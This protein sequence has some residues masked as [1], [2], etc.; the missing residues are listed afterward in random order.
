MSGASARPAREDRRLPTA[1]PDAA[2]PD[3]R[4]Q[5]A[6]HRAAR[7]RA[8]RHRANAGELAGGQQR[9]RPRTRT[10][11]ESAPMQHELIATGTDIAQ[12][13]ALV[14]PAMGLQLSHAQATNEITAIGSR[15]DPAT[16]SPLLSILTMVIDRPTLHTGISFG[17]DQQRVAIGA[18]PQ[19]SDLTGSGSSASTSTTARNIVAGAPG[20]GDLSGRGPRL[21]RVARFRAQ[22]P[23]PG[24][25]KGS[26]RTTSVVS[27]HPPQPRVHHD[28]D[29]FVATT[30]RLK[31]KRDSTAV[32]RLRHRRTGVRLPWTN[33]HLLIKLGGLL[34]LALLVRARRD[35]WVGPH[36]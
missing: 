32:S 20:H 5:R 36:E 11:I 25:P 29:G 15:A 28:I 12:C 6:A 18:F 13:I 14:E 27:P 1:R 16:S 35:R 7:Q 17:R 23:R 26:L 33:A 31:M 30:R 9:A 22:P 8:C 3:I 21:A 4:A 34:A 19:P 2:A 10:G 24:R